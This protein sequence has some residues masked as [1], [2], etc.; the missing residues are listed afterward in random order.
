MVEETS[1]AEVDEETELVLRLNRR[2]NLLKVHKF[3][4]APVRL[5]ECL[6]NRLYL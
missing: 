6:E 5:V 4:F 3:L 1:H 2:P